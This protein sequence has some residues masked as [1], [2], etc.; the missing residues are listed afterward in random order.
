MRYHPGM[1]TIRIAGFAGSL[2]RGSFNRRLLERA[3]TGAEA[4]GAEV[5]L[6]DLAEFD[7]PLYH[8]DLEA[9]QGLPAGVLAFK[10]R[11]READGFLIASPEYNGSVSPVLKNL[12]DWASRPTS[13]ETPDRCLDGKVAGLLSTSPGRLGGIRG[14]RHLRE[15]LH[16]VGILVTPRQYALPGAADAFAEDGSLTEGHCDDSTRAVGEEVARMAAALR[17][18]G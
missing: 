4:A 6:I 1:K 5:D 14:L 9:E 17:S 3:A 12:I 8:G 11:I 7:L 18:A 13:R 2:R 15:I 10:D 16:D